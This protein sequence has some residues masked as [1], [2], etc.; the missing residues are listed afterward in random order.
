MTDKAIM[1]EVI[2]GDC[3]DIAVKRIKDAQQQMRLPI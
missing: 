3:R 1:N 2:L